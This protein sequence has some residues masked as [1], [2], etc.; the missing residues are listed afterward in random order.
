MGQGFYFRYIDS[1]TIGHKG[2]SSGRLSTPPAY[3]NAS[4]IPH[5]RSH[6]PA[7]LAS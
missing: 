2:N 3:T 5:H 1:A 6:R 7:T 4:P